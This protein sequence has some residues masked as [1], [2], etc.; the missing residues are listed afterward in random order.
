MFNEPL[1]YM[2]IISIFKQ[3]NSP[4]QQEKGCF[5]SWKKS[6]L[7]PSVAGQIYWQLCQRNVQY[8]KEQKKDDFE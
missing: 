5:L 8:C 6:F 3:P 1:S 4:T 7:L 2:Y